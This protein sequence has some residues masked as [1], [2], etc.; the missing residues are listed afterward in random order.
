MRQGSDLI[1]TEHGSSM[2]VR[3]LWLRFLAVHVSP[4]GMFQG[5]S[6]LLLPSGMVFFTALLRRMVRMCR[7]VV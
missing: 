2:L 5:L 3:R 6:G 1:V 7:Q 4:L